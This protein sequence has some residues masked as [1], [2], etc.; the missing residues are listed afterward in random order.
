MA[1]SASKEMICKEN[2]RITVPVDGGSYIYKG[3][4]V[5]KNALGFAAPEAAEADGVFLGVAL[6]HKDNSAGADG[7]VSVQLQ[8]EGTFLLTGTG[9][10]QANL[11]EKVYASADN[12]VS[13]TQAS[14]EHQVGIV[15]E[16]VSS[17]QAWVRLTSA[18]A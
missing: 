17:T 2:E 14:N 10:S 5:K 9:F 11:G 4:L 12:A 8:T 7:A 15:T 18:A 13:P 3:A 16:Y 6:E 1:L